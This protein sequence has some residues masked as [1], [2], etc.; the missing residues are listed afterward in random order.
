MPDVAASAGAAQCA[1]CRIGQSQ[2]RQRFS[3]P[4]V[5]R[6]A[7]R[8]VPPAATAAAAAASAPAAQSTFTCQAGDAGQGSDF[9]LL[10]FVLATGFMEGGG[11]L[12]RMRHGVAIMYS[13]PGM[14]PAAWLASPEQHTARALLQR[15]A[16]RP[17][18]D[19]R[20]GKLQPG[21]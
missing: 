13:G 19:L 14:S 18:V 4:L 6:M 12:G 16:V 20:F 15:R 2:S 7:S 9:F 17:S 10:G 8:R 5:T 3:E 1:C 21:Q 11:D